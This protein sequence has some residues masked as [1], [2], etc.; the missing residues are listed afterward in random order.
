MRRYAVAGFPL[1]HSFSPKFF[2]DKFLKE[3]IDDCIYE[4]LPFKNIN[5]L[6]FY[7]KTNPDLEGINITIPYKKSILQFLTEMDDVV[8]TT[9][10]CNCIKIHE[11]QLFGFN[12][13]V[14]G[15]EKSL[16]PILQK[17]HSRALIL[18][19]G[20]AASS[21]AF[22]LEKLGIQY[23]FVS[24]NKT[25]YTFS[26]GGISEEII[27][28]HLLIVNT[29]PLGMY[30]SM[31]QSPDLPYH[32]LTSNHLL[33][34]LIYNPEKT[35]FLKRGETMGCSIKNGLEMLVIQAEESWKI[36]NKD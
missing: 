19:T 31:D 14:I 10:S 3:K 36:W 2:S 35:L 28:K 27:S 32:L 5:D 18:G 33:Y 16:L 17:H 25:D 15:F 22:V 26:Y 34:D 9:G 13:D 1:S 7:I 30:P 8:A 6:I 24:R 11:N 29:T 20:G 4:A 23:H 21:V 12:T